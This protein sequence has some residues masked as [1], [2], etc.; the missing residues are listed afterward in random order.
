MLPPVDPRVGAAVEVMLR[1]PEANQ[2]QVLALLEGCGFTAPEAWRV[3]QFL[4]IAFAHVVFRGRGVE[5]QPGY[6]LMDPDSS[7]RSTH[8][9]A[10]EP[11]YAAGVAAAEA[12]VAR[13][14]TPQQLL[15]VFGR[16]A[17]Y[18][19]IRQLAGPD[20]RLDGVVLTEPLLMTFGGS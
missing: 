11:L 15:P 8:R 5:F 7:A 10:D 12:R 2:D 4:A 3:Y 20:G 16:S 1:H 17:E 14:G 6:V 9:L 18:S 13:G 19:V